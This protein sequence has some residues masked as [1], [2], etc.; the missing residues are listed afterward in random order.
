MTD[1][2]ENLNGL[3]RLLDKQSAELDELGRNPSQSPLASFRLARAVIVDLANQL[4][5]QKRGPA[6]LLVRTTSSKA[7]A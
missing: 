2:L 5:I 4:H 3:A 1:L 7:D 6:A